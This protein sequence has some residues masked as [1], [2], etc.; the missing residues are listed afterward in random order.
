MIDFPSAPCLPFELPTSGPYVRGRRARFIDGRILALT[1]ARRRALAEPRRPD[2]LALPS[3]CHLE[4]GW[5]GYVAPPIDPA[6]RVKQNP[7]YLVFI[8]IE[9]GHDL[10]VFLCD[11]RSKGPGLQSEKSLFPQLKA[12]LRL[13]HVPSSPAGHFR[14]AE[15]SRLSHTLLIRR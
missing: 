2:R 7:M 1:A 15:P 8:P 4:G 6:R 11:G 3:H 9:T 10:Y 13:D 5:P 14:M 12:C